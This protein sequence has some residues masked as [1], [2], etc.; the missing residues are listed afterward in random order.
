VADELLDRIRDGYRA[1]NEGD[2]DRTLEFLSPDVEWH[3]SAS[4]PGT[5]AVYEGH[6]GFRRFWEHL[7]EPWEN[8]HVEIESYE[9]VDD[10]AILRISFHGTGKD[11]GVEVDLPWFQALVVA[12]DKIVRS[13]LD[14]SIGDALE[15]LDVG[16]RWPEF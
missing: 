7:H 8:I 9:R 4:F 11:S 12:D 14:R 15:T 13:A 2:L 10:V 6:E 16:D 1:W 5:L 3:T